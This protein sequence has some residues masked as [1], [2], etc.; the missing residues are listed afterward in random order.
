MEGTSNDFGRASSDLLESY[1]V[2]I[3]GGGLAGLTL[4]IQLKKARPDTTIIVAERR[5]GPAPEAAFKVGESTVEISAHYF[6]NVVGMKDH[7]DQHQGRKCG[8]RYFFSREGNQDI[9][10]RLEWGFSDHSN[11]PTYQL[12]R[13]RFENELWKR[14]VEAGVHVFDGCRVDEVDLSKGGHTLRL[15]REDG[16]ETVSARWVVDATGRASLLKRK[17][18]LAKEVEHKINSSWFR[19]AGGLD[20]EDFSDDPAWLGRMAKRGL[21]EASTNHL[22]GEGYWLWLIPLASGPISIGIVADPR[23]HPFDEINTLDG[24]LDWINRH[25][26]QVGEALQGRRDQIEDFLKVEHFSFS[27]ERVYSP[28]RWCLTG[29]AGVF[30]DPLYSPGSD[31]IAMGNTFIADVVARDLDGEDVAGR[32]EIFNAQL[33]LMFNN[34]L[35]LYTDHYPA[36]GSAQVMNAKLI[37]DFCVYWAHIAPRFVKGKLADL[38]FT[39]G[40]VEYLQASGRLGASVQ[41]LFQAWNELGGRE[42]GPGFVATNPLPGVWDLLVE[43]GQPMDDAVLQAKYAENLEFLQAL[44]VLVFHAA[45]RAL[46]DDRIDEDTPINYFALSLDPSKWED[47]DGMLNGDGIS[48]AQAR[49][50]AP[51]LEHVMSGEVVK[52]P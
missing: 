44:S 22:T 1:D 48:L 52:T 21:R 17:L 50:R 51:G 4:G 23:I 47:E 42:L 7:M 28:D 15:I 12:D 14:A 9:T 5:S 11:F 2:A 10:Q 19:L 3:L 38:E 40:I 8:L 29:E 43:L 6:A 16:T 39:Q 30:A 26:A 31:F 24:A 35:R 34:I 45:A 13:G 27:S 37:W 18:G 20:I 36:F 46:D 49:E 41:P 33:L 32:V 25:E